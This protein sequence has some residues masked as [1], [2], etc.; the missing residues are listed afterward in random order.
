M[1]LAS[2]LDAFTPFE[3]APTLTVSFQMI[4]PVRPRCRLLF[5]RFCVQR[6]ARKSLSSKKAIRVSA[7]N[8]DDI[9]CDDVIAA[10][11][12]PESKMNATKQLENL[13]NN[14]AD[15]I[16]DLVNDT[17]GPV[18][19]LQVEREVPGF[20]MSSIP[21]RY[22]GFHRT[23]GADFVWGGITEAAE[24]ALRKIIYGKKVAIQFVTPQPYLLEG[25]A[26]YL[27][28]TDW[29]PIMLLPASGANID[30]P[31]FL[32]RLSPESQEDTLARPPSSRRVKFR[33]L[34]PRPLRFAADYFSIGDPRNRF[35]ALL[36]RATA[37]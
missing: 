15:A 8:K 29:L 31:S 33:L 26:R 35:A 18:T 2:H 1:V 22:F 28:R 34:T 12:K 17:D 37:A 9:R 36:V 13:S 23:D 25:S 20:A 4:S 7:E 6:S 16:V 14:V 27:D 19:L 3:E 24:A 10:F 30:G 5:S 11:T 21:A 32:A